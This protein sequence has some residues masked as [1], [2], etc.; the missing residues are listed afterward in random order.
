MRLSR[1]FLPILR[2]EIEARIRVAGRTEAPFHERLVWF[3]ANHFTVSGTKP[4]VA[5]V[6]LR[7][8]LG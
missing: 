7:G 6:A 1:Y 8:Q 5:A 4:A 3:W 2:D